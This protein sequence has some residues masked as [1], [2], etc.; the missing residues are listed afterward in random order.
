[1][2]GGAGGHS[3]VDS[4]KGAGL[5]ACVVF[6]RECELLC[7]GGV[8]IGIDDDRSEHRGVA[9]LGKAHKRAHQVFLARE[10]IKKEGVERLALECPGGVG[11]LRAVLVERRLRRRIDGQTAGADRGDDVLRLHLVGANASGV[12]EVMSESVMIESVFAK[13]VW[14]LSRSRVA[15]D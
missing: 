6:V 12:R 5:Q 8:K 2:V 11:V 7:C 10:A 13:S 3:L 15:K 14:P 1:M 4:E 9:H